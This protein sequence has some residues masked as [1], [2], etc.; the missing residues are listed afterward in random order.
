MAVDVFISYATADKTIADAVCAKLEAERIRCWIAP[1]D[2]PPGSSWAAAIVDAIDNCRVMVLVFSAQANISPHT[3]REVEK[4]VRRG[5]PIVP[6]R[7]ENVEPTKSM[8][9]FL[10]TLHWLDALTPPL[11]RHLD[12][13]AGAVR[14]HLDHAQI[15]SEALLV[16]TPIGKSNQGELPQIVGWIEKSGANCGSRQLFSFIGR[17]QWTLVAALAASIAVMI[18]IALA[19]SS[20]L[21]CGQ[22]SICSS[23]F[24]VLDAR[25]DSVTFRP[26]VSG[27]NGIAALVKEV[28]I[29]SPREDLKSNDAD[30]GPNLPAIFKQGGS[31]PLTLRIR[32]F[33]AETP[34]GA[35]VTIRHLP[36]SDLWFEIETEPAPMEV[37]VL[38]KDSAFSVSLP[39][40]G[41]RNADSRLSFQAETNELRFALSEPE[42]AVPGPIAVSS[43]AF[44][45]VDDP[46]AFAPNLVTTLKECVLKFEGSYGRDIKRSCADGEKLGI[47]E[48]KGDIGTIRMSKIG[49]DTIFSGEVGGVDI[50]LGDNT[51]INLMPTIYEKYFGSGR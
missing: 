11:E 43:L 38:S 41:E 50:E 27:L 13:L 20:Q 46:T 3:C 45:D 24:V 23:A 42:L 36:G 22:A 31:V 21:H 34:N 7:I 25:S 15:E 14:G 6:L 28:D 33:N 8:E 32:T 4:A 37:A 30:R 5:I 39:A 19:A 17:H 40:K 29:I 12:R 51:S 44:A 10:R 16:K 18:V 1:R 48:P 2:A 47:R 9:H 49:I 26:G 35:S